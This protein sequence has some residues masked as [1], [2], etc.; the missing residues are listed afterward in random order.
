MKTLQS[1]A[2]LIYDLTPFGIPEIPYFASQNLPKTE[3][4]L[5]PHLHKGLME[6]CYTVKG[7]RLYHVAGEDYRVI[8]NQLFVTWPDEVHGSGI[9]PH[10]RAALLWLQIRLPRNPKTFLGMQGRN[11][12]LLVDKLRRMPRRHF[13]GDRILQTIF[14]KSFALC[15]EKPTTMNRLRLG[16]LLRELLLTV[17]ECSEM[18]AEAKFPPEIIPVLDYI[19]ENVNERI[20]IGRLAEIAHLSESR[21]KEKFKSSVGMPPGEYVLRRKVEAARQLLLE[22]K[23]T[24]TDVALSLG[25]FSLQH[26]SD[27]FRKFTGNSPRE[28]VKAL[29]FGRNAGSAIRRIGEIYNAKNPKLRRWVH[30]GW[31]HGHQLLPDEEA[32]G[33]LRELL[34]E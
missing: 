7:E 26:F 1:G 22:R 23:L 21:L 33:E 32:M 8:G 17:I 16:N 14:H 19:E 3:K 27:T 5:L 10:G 6:I 25:F 4:L 11:A 2:R 18:R 31:V 34:A 9:F 24:L 20:A 12:K 29:T 15:A 30:D 13:P 28:Y